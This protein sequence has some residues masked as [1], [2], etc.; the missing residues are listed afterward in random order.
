MSQLRSETMQL[1]QI[2]IKRDQDWDTMHQLF[3]LDCL[4][5]VDINAHIQPHQLLYA[6]IVRRCDETY[7]KIVFCE[8]IFKNYQVPMRA[9]ENLATLDH[10]SS[11]MQ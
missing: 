1:F 6:D 4:H 3:Q 11:L 2:Q 8:D 10:L 5:F 9:P 7:K